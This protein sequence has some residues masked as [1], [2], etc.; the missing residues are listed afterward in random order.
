MAIVLALDLA[1]VSG[2]AIYQDGKI[3][4]GRVRIHPGNRQGVRLHAF[5]KWLAEKMNQIGDIDFVVWE[6]AFC[7]PGKANEIHHNMVGVLLDWCEQH[8]I[9]Y[10]RVGVTT[11][12]KFAT[13]NGRAQKGVMIEAAAREGFRVIDDNEADAIHLLRYVLQNNPNLQGGTR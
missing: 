4:S 10:A 3:N 7:Q 9:G 12:K 1:T 13:G 5:R 6:H 11:I 8:R 2:F